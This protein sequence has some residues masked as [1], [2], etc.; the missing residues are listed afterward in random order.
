MQTFRYLKFKNCLSNPKHFLTIKIIN[1]CIV[2]EICPEPLSRFNVLF[3]KIYG[4]F[5]LILHRINKTLIYGTIEQKAPQRQKTS[6]P[7]LSLA[8]TGKFI[9]F[10]YS[11]C[12]NGKC[13]RGPRYFSYF[14]YFVT[15]KF[16][17]NNFQLMMLIMI[18]EFHEIK[19]SLKI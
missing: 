7:F 17:F 4:N 11:V 16:Y 19:L 10:R 2:Q 13:E 12:V 1:F 18:N 9:F 5:E 15:C 8:F 3:H 6:Q 14:R